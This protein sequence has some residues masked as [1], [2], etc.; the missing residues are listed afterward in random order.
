MCTAPI[1]KNMKNINR[2]LAMSFALL[3][4]SGCSAPKNPESSETSPAVTEASEDIQTVL[5]V[6]SIE[7]KNSSDDAI[8]FVTEPVDQ[9]V[10]EQIASWTP[11]YKMPPAP[12]YEE[13]SVTLKGSDGETML[14]PCDAQV[15]VRGNWTTVYPK[16]PLKI[17]FTEKQNLLGLNDGAEQKSWLLLA[18]YKDASM[19]RNKAA[20]YAA[21]EIL[22]PDGLYSADS[23]LVNVEINGEYFGTYLLTE[24]QQIS[25]ERVDISE[26][27]KNYTGTDTGYF[28]EFDGYFTN[29][30]E[31]HSFPLDLADNAP[32]KV[33]DG[34]DSET[35]MQAL[36]T[37]E[38]DTKKP[39]GITIKSTINSQEQHDFI[40]N[41]VNNV[42]TI[43]YEAAY[44]DKAYVFD[45]DFK[46]ISETSTISPQQAVENVVD[47]QSLA[48]IY[49]ISE[50]TCDADI[51]WSSF[52]MDADFG[53]D[54]SKKLRFEAPWDFDS[55]MG[56]KD[57]CIDG[58]GFYASNVVPDVNGGTENG[59]E[60]DTINPWLVVLA[61]EDWYQDIVRKKWSEAYD[62]G[63][64]E[65]TFQLIENDKNTLK[66]DFE[67]NYQKWDNIRHNEDFENELSAPAEKCKNEAEAADFLLEWLKKRVDFLNS[68]WHE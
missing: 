54:G 40:E 48:D 50:L 13:C 56:N 57:R 11:F 22:S 29:E 38:D 26:P 14:S 4:L 32:L 59:G 8:K 31:L 18:E 6:L 30:D 51:Y 43:M 47:V 15:K 2:F 33:Y 64:F 23:E 39:V 45:K 52:F 67:K 9:Y 65:R 35:Y 20:L 17:K 28:L 55:A 66:N 34:T 21:N 25:S 7:T 37:D 10:A 68:Q 1:I 41:F 12:Y 61:N 16:K 19:L 49:I 44:N 5:P 3:M 62:N 27:D 46:N 58:T 24:S 60:Y 53:A 42:Y 36:P 63:V